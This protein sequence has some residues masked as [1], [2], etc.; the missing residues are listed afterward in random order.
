[1]GFAHYSVSFLNTA[2]VDSEHTLKLI[3]IL[4]PNQISLGAQVY[5][6]KSKNFN[7]YSHALSLHLIE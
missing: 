2:L 1:M 3:Q 5:F 7:I 6:L 4:Q